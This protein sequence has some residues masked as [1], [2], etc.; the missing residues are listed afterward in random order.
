MKL[1]FSYGIAKWEQL[2]GGGCKYF[3][4]SETLS[5]MSRRKSHLENG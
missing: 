1:V 3:M 5:Q 4:V 2:L